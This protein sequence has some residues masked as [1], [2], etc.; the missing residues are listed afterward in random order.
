Q[1]DTQDA[2]ERQL[3]GTVK[4]DQG[5]V[6][7][8]RLQLSFTHVTAPIAGRAGLKQ[9]DLGNVVQPSDPAGIVSI[10]QTRPIALLF[11]VPAA[12]VPLISAGLR[13]KAAISV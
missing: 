3:E 7:S 13:T 10:S 2:L 12:H 5:L 6:D 1:L 9:V 8:A 11:S 4:A